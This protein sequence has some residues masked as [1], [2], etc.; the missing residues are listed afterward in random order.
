MPT[1]GCRNGDTS[2]DGFKTRRPLRAIMKAATCFPE[3]LKTEADRKWERL[4]HALIE[5]GVRL[6][7]NRAFQL[8]LK[9]VL[10]LSDFVAEAV[11]RDPHLLADLC[12]GGQLRDA[13]PPG[14]YA[15][16]LERVLDGA[17]EADD[18]MRRLRRYRCREMVRIAWRDLAGHSDLTETTADLSDLAEA[19]LEQ[20]LAWLYRRQ[21]AE[22]G[23]PVSAD[24]QPMGLAVLALGKLGARE[25]NFSSDI[26]LIFAFRSA[27]ETREADRP[28]TN[29]EFFSRL[30]RKLIQAIGQ[31]TGDGIV[32]RVDLR[33]RPHGDSGPVV[34]SF[35][36]MEHYYQEQGRDWERY[37]WIK[38]R[39]VAGDRPAGEELLK[40]LHPF[41]YRRYLDFGAFESLRAMKRMIS[42]E[43]ARKGLL[44][45]IKL[46]PG[47]IREVEFFGQIFQLIRGGVSPGLQKRPIREVLSALAADGHIPQQA[48]RELDAAYVFLRYVEHRLQE[49][50]DQQT[51]TLPEDLLGRARL[52]ASMGFQ[53]YSTFQDA[54]DRHRRD[55]HGHF[56]MLL[57]SGEGDGADKVLESDLSDVWYRKIRGAEAAAILGKRGYH[58][59]EEALMV[60]EDMRAGFETR[61]LSPV[62]RQRLDRLVPLVLMEAAQAA[63]PL[64]TL[65]RIGDL[66]RAVER[67]TSYLALLLEYPAAIQHLVKLAHASPWIASFLAQHPVLLDEL[68]DPRTLYRPPDRASLSGEIE[69]RLRQAP[70]D[71]LEAQI[72]ELCIFKQINVLRV[73]AADV[74]GILPLMR[75][76]DYLSDIA[77]VAVNAVVDLAWAHLVATHGAP[78]C[79]LNGKRCERGFAVLAY[80]KL[81]GLELG[82]ASDLDLVFLHAGAEGQTSGGARPIDNSQ[83]F[84]RLGQRVIHILTAHTRAGRVY[85][86]D[87]RLRASGISGI[88]VQHVE[89][90]RDYQL[91][92]AWTW[93]HQAL[94]KARPVSGDRLLTERFEAI[95]AEVLSRVREKDRLRT[96]VIEMRE[97]M[98]RERQRPV[99]GAFDL[100]Q[101]P[102]GIVDIEFLVQYLVLLHAHRIAELVRWTDNVRLIQTLIGSAV[103][104][105]YTAHVLK[106]A[107]LIYRA[108]AHQLGLQEKPARVPYEKFEALQQRIRQIWRSVFQSR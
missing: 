67:R 44:Q 41:V 92:E 94:I 72:E 24:G 87:T 14:E 77:E 74:S 82:Y 11:I 10:A 68:L 69:R 90:F 28:V 99:P 3:I 85:E 48:Q 75:V 43:V 97:R 62:G 93:E 35:D 21:C 25:L 89:A 66:I 64:S 27:G 107:Y 51:H 5:T 76:S 60:L 73:A 98:R 49:V 88:L 58:P 84:N 79:I 59:S 55:A 33:L 38:A 40:R 23:V 17:E 91:D 31:P 9:G 80:G 30:C 16:R 101:D 26:D 106:H 47:G 95:R 42:Q 12:T 102:G 57:E 56:Q 7:E 105:E 15:S 37:A 53:D 83:F 13:F 29:E 18:L 52:A 22:Q 46:G 2:A 36:A 4:Q 63:N 32:F 71:D 70:D 19:C 20:T 65:K 96:E 39:M 50:A 103:L 104:D 6:P 34:M 78:S 100:K 8:E 108:A 1:G 61:S 54:L 81:G 45:N 86:I